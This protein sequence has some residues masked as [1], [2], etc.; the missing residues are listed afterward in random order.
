MKRRES[1]EISAKV[2]I[3]ALAALVAFFCVSCDKTCVDI[4]VDM[5]WFVAEDYQYQTV[6]FANGR[7]TLCVRYD[8]LEFYTEKSETTAWGDGYC[9]VAVIQ[10]GIFSN[11]LGIRYDMQQGQELGHSRPREG[12]LYEYGIEDSLGSEIHSLSIDED[13]WTS[14][15]VVFD[16]WENS[17]YYCY[18]LSWVSRY[19]IRYNRVLKH[20]FPSRDSEV[21]DTVYFADRK[22][23]VQMDLVSKGETWHL[24]PPD[25][26]AA[27]ANKS[28]Q[29]IGK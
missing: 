5:P 20:W 15:K 3:P 7:D 27:G 11:G 9:M 14:E 2:W 21:F 23:L 1:L 22:G 19:G 6:V 12:Y 26:E 29:M 10:E 13:F 8:G 24:I 16:G 17:S 4:P 28:L 25:M 18:L